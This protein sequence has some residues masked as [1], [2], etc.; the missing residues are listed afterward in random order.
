[1]ISVV[2][3]LF[4]EPREPASASPV[5]DALTR[6]MTAAYRAAQP[7]RAVYGGVHHCV[8]GEASTNQDYILTDGEKTNSLCVRYLAFHR[9]EVPPEQL[10]R[11]AARSADEADPTEAS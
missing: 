9:G 1:M 8:C 7:G 6:R 10:R 4:I 3:L 11:V 5:I 2:D